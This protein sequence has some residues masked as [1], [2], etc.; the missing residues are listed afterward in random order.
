[1]VVALFVIAAAAASAPL[2]AIVLVSVA[3][4]REDRAW[5]LDGPARGPVEEIARCIVDFRSAGQ[6]PQPR[7]RGRR[8]FPRVRP[9]APYWQQGSAQ[10]VTARAGDEGIGN[11]ECPLAKDR[12][13]ICR[14]LV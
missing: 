12:V 7:S 14:P 3:S 9:N 8:P 6:W 5:S 4:R 1:M 2:V 13:A 10:R 11:A